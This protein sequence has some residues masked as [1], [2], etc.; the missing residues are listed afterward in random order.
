M[1]GKLYLNLWFKKCKL[2]LNNRKVKDAQECMNEALDLSLG[3]DKKANIILRQKIYY[4]QARI[5]ICSSEHKLA[6]E[7]LVLALEHG[8]IY[9]STLRYKILKTL[10]KLF[11]K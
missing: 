8:T 5:Y 10:S 1:E 7:N 11:M 3:K 4:Y 9:V 2:L 6:A